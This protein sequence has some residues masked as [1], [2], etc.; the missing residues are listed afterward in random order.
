MTYEPVDHVTNVGKKV[1]LTVD[2]AKL[3]LTMVDDFPELSVAH[4]LIKRI[5]E[6]IKQAEGK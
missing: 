2:E 6:R 5:Q 3:L 1:V 4:R